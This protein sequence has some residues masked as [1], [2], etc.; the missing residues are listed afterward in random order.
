[1]WLYAGAGWLHQIFQYQTREWQSLSQGY[2]Y[3]N[4]NLMRTGPRSKD[5]SHVK[6][7][8]SA[9]WAAQAPCL[10]CPCSCPC[11]A[12]PSTQGWLSPAPGKGCKEK[13]ALLMSDFLFLGTSLNCRVA[14]SWS[15]FYKL[16]S[17]HRVPFGVSWRQQWL[18]FWARWFFKAKLLVCCGCDI[19]DLIAVTVFPRCLGVAKLCLDIPGR[20]QRNLA[21]TDSFSVAIY[22]WQSKIH[23][24]VVKKKKTYIKRGEVIPPARL[25]CKWCWR[26]FSVAIH[27][28]SSDSA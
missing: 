5:A 13:T 12:K 26:A 15:K 11:T 3:I 28:F 24:L 16:K 22:I 21:L 25:F 18:S 4:R 17:W 19:D 20:S 7:S 6:V 10:L 9:G 1:M 23:K 14:H 8:F 2:L 27:A